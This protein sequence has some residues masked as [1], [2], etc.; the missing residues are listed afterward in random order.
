MSTIYKDKNEDFIS[1]SKWEECN[2]LIL[3][4]TD[5]AV[6]TIYDKETKKYD[7]AKSL[8]ECKYGDNTIYRFQMVDEEGLAC[9][10]RI[11]KFVDTDDGHLAT[12]YIDYGNTTYV[13]RL[14]DSNSSYNMN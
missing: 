3:I 2:M 7:I 6:L 12:L 13:Y 5:P 4:K 8:K 11:L 9:V 10:L 1:A 14:K